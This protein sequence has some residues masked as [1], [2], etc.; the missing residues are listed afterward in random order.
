[1][2]RHIFVGTA[3][4][5]TTPE[6]LDE[7]LAAWRGLPSRVSEIRRMTAGRNI[8]PRDQ[9]YTVAL[10]ADFDDMDAWERYMNHPAHVALGQRLTAK[11]IKPDSRAVVQFIM[12]DA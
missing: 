1:M 3:K 5:D 11:L 12:E 9:R 4:E 8:S 10:V 2:I 6:Q 7:L